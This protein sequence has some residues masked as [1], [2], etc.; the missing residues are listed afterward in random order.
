MHDPSGKTH[1]E[2]S[3][4]LLPQSSFSRRILVAFQILTSENEV[5]PGGDHQ[6]SQYENKIQKCS[7]KPLLY[8]Q[9]KKGWYGDFPGGP[10]IKNPLANEG[11]MGSIPGPGSFHM[12]RGN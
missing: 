8:N 3:A 11:H 7:W 9:A 6:T 4:S 5:W 1:R 10:V 12:L 2:Q